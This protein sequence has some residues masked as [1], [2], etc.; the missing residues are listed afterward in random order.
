MTRSLGT[1]HPAQPSK[2]V[3]MSVIWTISLLTRPAGTCPGQT[4]CAQ[5]A[6]H[7][8]EIRSVKKAG[9]ASPREAL[10]RPVVPG[11]YHDG[12]VGDAQGVEKVEQH[13]EIA[14]ELQQA[15]GPLTDTAF[16]LE[17]IARHPRE[18]QKRVVE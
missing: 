4:R 3:N 6:F 14:V 8:S 16:T 17:L 15:V 11:E 5:R 10:L 9:C 13:A 7:S 12:V 1:S 18:M 2:V